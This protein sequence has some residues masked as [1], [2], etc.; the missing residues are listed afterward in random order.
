MGEEKSGSLRSVIA[1]IA[2]ADLEAGGIDQAIEFVLLARD[3]DAR[4]GDA[5]NAMRATA[6]FLFATPNA[7]RRLLRVAIAF[8]EYLADKHQTTDQALGLRPGRGKYERPA[9]EAHAEMI[10]IALRDLLD[11]KPFRTIAELNGYAEKEFREMFNRYKQYA[12]ERL[13][14]DRIKAEDWLDPK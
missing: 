12:I 8:R 11:G 9:D 14:A 10:C 13:A 5:L 6:D 1:G 3:D 4:F 7:S 2:G